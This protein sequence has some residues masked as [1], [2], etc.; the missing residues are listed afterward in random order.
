[1]TSREKLPGQIL[2]QLNMVIYHMQRTIG[3][4]MVED[5]AK[6]IYLVL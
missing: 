2:T 3:S 4:R 6:F 5:K 1:M